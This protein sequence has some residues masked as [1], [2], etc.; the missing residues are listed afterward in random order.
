MTELD[1]LR[2][3]IKRE[4]AARHA[5][6]Q[7]LEERALELYHANQQLRA[8]ND[9]LE[10]EVARQRVALDREHARYQALVDSAQDIIFVLSPEGYFKYINPIAFQVTGYDATDRDTVTFHQLIHPDHVARVLQFYQHQLQ[11]REAVT[12][13]EFPIIAKDGSQIWLG[14]NTRLQFLPNGEAEWT[15]FARDIT[16]RIEKDRR[17]AEM[18][19]A[20]QQ[21]EEKYRGIIEN[22]ELGL[23]EVDPEGVIIKPY[24]RFCEMVGYTADEL[25]GRKANDVFLPEAYAERMHREDDNRRRGQAGVYEMKL[26]L[27]DNR[28]KWVL[29]SGAPFYDL[30]GN[31]AGSIGI[32]YDLTEQKALQEALEAARH[33]AER[34]RDAE[35]DFLANM[36]H[37]IR[38][39]INAVVG[40]THLLF[41]T[42]LDDAQR[43]YLE[44]IKYASD[45]LLSLISDILDISKITEGKMELHLRPFDLADTVRAVGNTTRFRLDGSAVTFELDHDTRIPPSLRTDTTFLN[46]ILMNLL[47]NAVKFTHAGSITL[48]TRLVSEDADTATVEFTVQDTG[49]GIPAAQLPHIFDR[50]NQAG[51]ATKEQYGGTGLGLPITK[52]LIEEL[53]GAV[54]VQS[55]VGEG[56]T[57]AFYLPFALG[58][59]LIGGSSTQADTALPAGP[60]TLR[61]LIVED[62]AM[63]RL[64]LERIFDKWGYHYDSSPHGADALER[65]AAGTYDLILMDI[66]MPVMDGYETTIR[67]R[68]DHHNANRATPI[69]ALTASALTDEKDRALRAGMDYHLTKPFTPELLRAA[70]DSLFA[71]NPTAPPVKQ[72]ALT[73]PNPFDAAELHELYG[74]DREHALMMLELFLEETPDLFERLTVHIDRAAYAEARELAHQI[75]PHFAMIG[76]GR[77]STDMAEIEALC[78]A[79]KAESAERLADLVSGVKFA[80]Q[81][82]RTAARRITTTEPNKHAYHEQTK[83]P[84]RR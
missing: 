14:Q 7:L 51:K 23:M 10:G 17:L 80:V 60:S 56:T 6:E 78:R 82:I 38:N 35:K 53:G 79:P 16:E 84:D 27:K 2:R 24:P 55:T 57:F 69:I 68:A 22:M 29:I 62:N 81:A 11:T 64:Y 28:S 42:P 33:E 77:Y 9:N 26:R 58:A 31:M 8:L 20:I 72:S 54:E 40:M 83:L 18:Q 73:W 50:F 19:T 70:I 13:T 1:I 4:K 21:S 71:T 30:E 39:P 43:Q 67:L 63:N 25:I 76:C 45:L 65:L 49:I 5:A 15:A 44:N 12:Y 46:Q 3:K 32:H 34:A 74:D 41:D 48:R 59:Q 37:E 47:G 75:K 66:R 36:S 61:V 52:K